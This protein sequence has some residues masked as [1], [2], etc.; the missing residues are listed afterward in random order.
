MNADEGVP[1]GGDEMATG[2]A[3]RAFCARLAAVGDRISAEAPTA[4]AAAEGF[5]HLA[6]QV[7]CWLTYA[8][9]HTDPVHPAFF[10]S[11]DPVYQWGGP[12]ADQVARRAAIDGAGTYRVSGHMGSCEEF[13]LQ[14]KAGAAQSGGARVA[15]EISASELGLSP[16]DDIDLVVGGAQQPDRWIPLD[17]QAAFV[18]LRDYYF[19]WQASDPATFVIERLD[20]VAEPRAPR[21]ARRVAAM[22]DD[23]AREVEHSVTFWSGYQDRMLAGKAPNAFTDPGAAAGGVQAIAYS[24]ASVA[25][26]DDEALIVEL[27]PDD[28]ALWDV[29]LYN[30][31]WYE[32]LD[33]ANRVTS[34]NHRLAERAADG[35]VRIVIAARDPGVVNWLDTEGRE[36]VLA[37]VRWWHP[38]GPPTVRA[39]LRPLA[40][41]SG[42]LDPAQRREQIRRRTSHAA[43]RYRT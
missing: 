32:A 15:Y 31:P 12:N 20:A 8:I 14:I 2:A 21:D 5:H 42:A 25:V 13:V 30:R 41:V 17:P 36:A 38:V 1:R 39:E 4:A 18:H 19:D 6:N 3:W 35:R 37:T 28:A 24:H 29:Q 16:G 27:D 40:A 11:S 33:F 10:R 23:A 7:A 43:W 26:G 22:L 9:G 34:T